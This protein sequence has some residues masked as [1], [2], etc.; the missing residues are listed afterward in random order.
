M[1]LWPTWAGTTFAELPFWLSLDSAELVGLVLIGLTARHHPRSFTIA[2]MLTA[3]LLFCDAAS[4]ISL[5]MATGDTLLAVATAVLVELP[6]GFLLLRTA[7]KHQVG[8][9]HVPAINA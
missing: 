4:D 5:S 6:A 9:P 1:A 8:H 7:L 3:S 2:S